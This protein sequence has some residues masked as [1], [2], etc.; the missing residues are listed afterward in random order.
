MKLTT[1]E[2][3]AIVKR[4]REKALGVNSSDLKLERKTALDYYHGDVSAHMPDEDGRSTAVS[5]DVS[6]TVEGLMSPLMEIFMGGDKVVEF[7]PVGP[8]DE[9]PAQQETDFVNHVFMQRNP[10]YIVMYHFIKDALLSKIGIVKCYWDE[11]EREETEHYKDQDQVSAMLLLGQKSDMEIRNIETK[12]DPRTGGALY[13]VTLVSTR[14]YGCAKLDPVPPE[15]FGISS[16]ARMLKDA[17]YCYHEPNNVTES[18]L[19]GQGYDKEQVLGLPD[20]S[21][22][23]EEASARDTNTKS[24]ETGVDDGNDADH[25]MRRVRVI[26]H[27]KRMDLEGDGKPKLY[28]ITTGGDRFEILR[29]NGKDDIVEVD[30]MPFAA[31]TPIINP[32]RFV[33]RSIADQV[34]DIQR[35]KTALLRALLDNAYLAN[36]MRT[37]VSESH[38]NEYTIE[39]LMDNRSGGIVRTR[40]PGGLAPIPSQ[41]IGTFAYPL[42]EYLDQQKELRTGFSRQGQGLD[43]NALQNQ[44][45]TA[46]NQVFTAA[47]AR[48]KMIAR[49]IA[50]TGVRDL[51]SLLHATLRKN[52]SQQEIVRLR[53]T[54]QPIDPRTWRTRDDMTIN[55]G[56]GTGSKQEQLLKLQMIAAAQEKMLRLGGVS[57]DNAHHTAQEFVK[58]AGYRNPDAFFRNPTAP[59]DPKN[60]GSQPIPAPQDPKE[61]KYKQDGQIKI[62]V[63]QQ[64]AQAAQQADQADIMRE[65]IQA[66]A[67]IAVEKAKNMFAMQ[68]KQ[69]EAEQKKQLIVLQAAIKHGEAQQRAQDHATDGIYTVA[70][71]NQKLRHAEQVHDLKMR[72]LA[73]AASLAKPGGGNDRAS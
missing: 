33:G 3:E 5:S 59:P 72:E 70:E 56:L 47:Q 25:A 55:V 50:E 43:A 17:D 8:E 58:L 11:Y 16:S 52:A 1:T 23:E 32:H 63:E 36:N 53:N 22:G 38:S 21:G 19:I 39:D 35:I 57:Y 14:K 24:N 12:T 37:E 73:R 71:G 65:Q 28:R 51:F 29:R 13:D 44:S 30:F 66:Q 27:Y 4:E 45:A 31:A 34:M 15:E 62:A 48:M 2:V 6:D 49:T 54:W 18:D 20:V 61:Q 10:G 64:K 60:P 40:M 67:D 41:S 9:L 69:T 42:I 68:L 7:E 46:V 26:E